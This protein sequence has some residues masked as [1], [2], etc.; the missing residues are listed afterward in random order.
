MNRVEHLL[1][2]DV[3]VIGGGIAGCFAAVKAKEQEV[4]VILVDKGYVGKTGE[5]PSANTYA[6]FN[7]EWGDDLNGWMNQVNLRTEYMNNREW[8]EIVIKE[9]YARWQD[10]VSWGIE[11]YKWEPEHGAVI[12]SPASKNDGELIRLPQKTPEQKAEYPMQAVR[13]PF[14]TTGEVYRK[15]VL[16]TGVKIM[17]RIVIT[18]LLKQ[19]GRIV[20]AIGNTTD[21]YDLYILKA[22]ATAMCAGTAAFK[23]NG[24]PLGVITGDAD[25]IAYR[26]GC[27]ITGKEWTDTHTVRGD[28]PAWPSNRK[29]RDLYKAVK[30]DYRGWG[31]KYNAEGKRLSTEFGP[32]VIEDAYQAHVGRAPIWWEVTSGINE[33]HIM[34]NSPKGLPRKPLDDIAGKFGRVR[35]AY[36]ASSG[37]S[38]HVSSGIWPTNTK[39]ATQLPGLYA[40]GDSLGS[41]VSGADYPCYGWAMATC[42]V[43]GA[44]AGTGAAGDA[45]QAE[46]P[47]IDEL[48]L[49]R[50]EKTLYAPMERKG[51][52]TPGWV[53]QVLQHTMMPYWVSFIKRGDRLEAALTQIEFLRDNIVPK[54]MTSDPHELRLAH[55]VKSM[56]LHAEMKLR[57]SL[58]RTESRGSHYREDYP[59]RDDPAW[60]VWVKIKNENGCMKLS[61]EPIPKEWWPDLSIPD[62]KRYLTRF[63]VTDNSNC[64]S[65]AR[66][67]HKKQS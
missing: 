54:L 65:E 22:K 12:L 44:R 6:A 20:G 34:V 56:V 35:L 25:A 48:E 17:D 57:A 66:P 37:M 29:D 67:R 45:L 27:E 64:S 24:F 3:L 11:A 61:K 21:S 59:Q 50:L 62:E 32:M 39:C 2:T 49:A 18:D 19:D 43:T 10:M 58:F 14:W 33:W 4:D 8:T 9:S 16:K 1:E 5:S 7:P 36:G 15:A 26:V 28:F 52:F 30:N 40:A 38:Q 41:R 60:L 31:P 13:F 63:P 23:P 46:K 47:E 42:A 51:G 55:E 53:T